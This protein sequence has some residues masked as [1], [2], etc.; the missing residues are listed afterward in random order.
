MVFT[1]VYGVSRGLQGHSVDGLAVWSNPP[2]RSTGASAGFHSTACTLPLWCV[3]TC[4][5]AWQEGH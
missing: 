1:C 5:V 2:V 3:S 4:C